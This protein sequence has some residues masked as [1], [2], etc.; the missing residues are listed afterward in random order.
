MKGHIRHRHCSRRHGR[1]FPPA[2]PVAAAVSLMFLLA[3][4]CS[5]GTGTA[6]RT[7][8][9][10]LSREEVSGEVLWQRITEG[11][12]YHNYRYWPG[13]EGRNPGQAP[14]GPYHEIFINHH[15]FSALP[16]DDRTVPHG[17]IIVK[18]NYTGEEVLNSLTVM[19]KVEGFAP[20]SGNW[21]WAKYG[22]DGE[23]QAQGTPGPCITCHAGMRD[24]DYVIV[25]PLDKA[26][27]E[28]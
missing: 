19:A 3:A 13:H 5:D 2:V 18:E 16:I 4:G 25:R 6:E 22:P 9:P 12:D 26:L 15:I 17:G 24:N 1:R 10:P 8:L 7:D 14:H 21:F 28:E 27:P 20:D 11:S 23:I